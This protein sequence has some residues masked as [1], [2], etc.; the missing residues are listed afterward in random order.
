MGDFYNERLI[1]Q[2]RLVHRCEE[3]TRAIL[4]GESCLYVAGV[5]EGGFSAFHAHV[6]CREASAAYYDLCDSYYDD[7]RQWIHEIDPECHP[8]LIAEF[9]AV[10]KRLGVIK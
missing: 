10:A 8:W 4:L 5:Y 1:K 7:E 9:P 3:C 6:D 2:T